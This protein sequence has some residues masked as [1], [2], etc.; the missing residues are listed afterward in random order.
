M[1]NARSVLVAVILGLVIVSV[2]GYVVEAI[3]GGSPVPSRGDWAQAVASTMS[4]R[5]IP[6]AIQ[7]LMRTNPHRIREPG[8]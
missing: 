2:G 1:V 3:G 4:S 5:V 6:K 7:I 8:P